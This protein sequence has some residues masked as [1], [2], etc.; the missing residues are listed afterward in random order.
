MKKEVK[1]AAALLKA[2]KEIEEE[3]KDKKARITSEVTTPKAPKKETEIPS[4]NSIP[5][6]VPA[7]Q[8]PQEA[9]KVTVI[10]SSK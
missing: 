4:T 10:D 1:K 7:K 9:E 6:P 5:L 3:A 8:V 2:S